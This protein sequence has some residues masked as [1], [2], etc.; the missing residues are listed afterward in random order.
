MVYEFEELYIAEFVHMMKWNFLLAFY[1]F[2]FIFPLYDIWFIEYDLLHSYIYILFH[3][4]FE[5]IYTFS[6][7]F[8]CM[9][10]RDVDLCFGENNTYKCWIA[11]VYIVINK[12]YMLRTWSNSSHTVSFFFI[13][14]NIALYFHTYL[15]IC[16]TQLQNIFNLLVVTQQQQRRQ[17][18]QQQQQQQQQNL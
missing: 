1:L 11:Y 18:Q 5:E 12:V 7:S 2:Y 13:K 10:E 4:F 17:R 3:F 15:I 14:K 6:L 8:N 9:E 16:N